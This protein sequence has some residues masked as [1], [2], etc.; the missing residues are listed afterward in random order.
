MQNSSERKPIH[1]DLKCHLEF[2]G[3][4]NCGNKSFEVRKNDRDFR[5]GD[6]FQLRAFDK[7]TK[8]YTGQKSKIFKITYVLDL[9]KY[10][11]MSASAYVVFSWRDVPPERKFTQS[12]LTDAEAYE[13]CIQKGD[14]LDPRRYED[15]YDG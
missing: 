1:H 11:G 6:T 10:L 14:T 13:Q 3:K 5:T 2:F 4:V 15:G 7:V 8:E 9:D 12:R